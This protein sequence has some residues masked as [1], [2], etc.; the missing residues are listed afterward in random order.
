MI[1]GDK[2]VVTPG[3]GAFL[4]TEMMRAQVEELKI[5]VWGRE[6]ATT[7]REIIGAAR[8]GH[9]DVVT[10]QDPFWRGLIAWRTARAANAKL[11]LQ[12]HTDFIAQ[13]E[14]KR[15]LGA[16]LLR[17]A[18]GIRVVS[19]KIK[20]SLA[21]LN[22]KAPITVLPIF[23]DLDAVT[24]AIPA[25]KTQFSQFEQIVLVVS[26]LE[27]EKNV[28][29]AIRAMKEI[30]ESFPR[31]GLLIAGDG[32]EREKLQNL[33]Q[34]LGVE[35]H[36]LF[37]GHRDDVFSLYKIADVLL[38]PSLYEGF[39][40]VI[41]EALAVGC[42]VVSGDVGVA[43]QAGAVIADKNNFASTVIEVL[44]K[45]RHAQLAIPMLSQAEYVTLWRKSLNI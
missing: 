38:L 29:E 30:A 36:L 22:L 15:M 1:S 5:F 21:P 12:V 16:F 45:G 8:H 44:K 35:K 28:G 34:T 2:N 6:S 43:R 39:G 20:Q 11:Q 10:A 9:F 24:G 13:S 25:D 17:R 33:A 4:R 40:A 14:F 31:A 32:S 3:T 37:L 7:A 42:P 26:R 19:E 41:V 23:I 27:P 18:D